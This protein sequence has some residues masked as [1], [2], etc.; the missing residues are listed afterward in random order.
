[1]VTFKLS[2]LEQNALRSVA[3]KQGVSM[4]G[5]IR[6]ILKDEVHLYM[7]AQKMS[8][9]QALKKLTEEEKV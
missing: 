4:T 3:K 8:Y 6:E 2:E 7:V 9:V 1:M 5:Y